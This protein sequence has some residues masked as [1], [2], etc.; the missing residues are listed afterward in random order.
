ML[1]NNQ[2]LASS[3]RLSE[4]VLLLGDGDFTF[5]LSLMNG[6][7]HF[8]AVQPHPPSSSSSSSSSSSLSSSFDRCSS[9]DV[10][11]SI[12]IVP[13][14]FDSSESVLQKYKDAS[15]TIRKLT[16]NTLVRSIEYGVNAC[17]NLNW[18]VTERND[19]RKFDHIIFN[20]PHLGIESAKQNSYLLGHFA[21]RACE[22]LSDQ[23]L[24][25][26]AL[27]ED[28]SIRWH[29][30]AQ[31][32]RHALHSAG[33]L[34]INES[35][36]PGYAMKRHQSGRSFSSRVINCRS[37]FFS[38]SE[39]ISTNLQISTILDIAQRGYKFGSSSSSSSSSSLSLFSSSSSS[40]IL[41]TKP[42]VNDNVK[43]EYSEVGGKGKEK[44]SGKLK[45]RKVVELTE[46][47]IEI[48]DKTGVSTCKICKR[49]FRS[50]EGARTHVYMVHVIAVAELS[51]PLEEIYKKE[52]QQL[53]I[54]NGVKESEYNCQLCFKVFANA[55]SLEAHN[56]S[57]HGRFEHKIPEW[58]GKELSSESLEDYIKR[59]K[60]ELNLDDNKLEKVKSYSNPTT[61]KKIKLTFILELLLRNSN[62]FIKGDIISLYKDLK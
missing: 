39:H 11:A 29:L 20:F 17:E 5:S 32:K 4:S 53:E 1:M 31:M 35:M 13:T 10:S 59:Y 40:E 7:N 33:S 30:D 14:C 55:S 28:Q 9:S 6:L 25:Y 50:I 38:R 21:Q 24:V 56:K 44:S 49:N 3:Q 60:R 45:K 12:S 62:K 22:V 18:L 15:G 51:T 58:A 46:D 2:V 16:S 47:K 26:I 37:Y 19:G 52:G 57:K 23:G 43:R 48:D 61:F 42:I 36:W 8:M 54:I 41:T 27:A 34:P